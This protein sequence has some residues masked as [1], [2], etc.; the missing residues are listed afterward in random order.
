V[1]VVVATIGYRMVCVYEHCHSCGNTTGPWSIEEE[2][3]GDVLIDDES[4]T[5]DRTEDDGLG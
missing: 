1:S 5:V 4:T 2:R 3:D